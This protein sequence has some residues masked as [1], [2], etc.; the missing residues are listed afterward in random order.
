[1]FTTGKIVFALI[2][3]VVFVLAMAWSYKKD[4]FSTKIHFKGATKT[5]LLI[6]LVFL[7][8]FLFVKIRHLL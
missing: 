1:M 2:F 5:L 6:V 7:A 3:L 4:S 8:L